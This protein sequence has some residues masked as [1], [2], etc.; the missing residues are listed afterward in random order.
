MK[1]VLEEMLYFVS[2]NKFVIAM[3]STNEAVVITGYDTK[4]VFAYNPVDGK[5]QKIKKK[6]M[7]SYVKT[8][9]NRFFSYAD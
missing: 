6:V 3:T 7:E 2:N 8:G 5:Q 9:K 1:I 4:Y